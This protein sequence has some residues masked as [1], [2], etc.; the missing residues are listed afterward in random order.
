MHVF[1][2]ISV[3]AIEMENYKL[4]KQWMK[5]DGRNSSIATRI[6]SDGLP[7]VQVSEVSAETYANLAL[8]MFSFV[9][10]TCFLGAIVGPEA[11]GGWYAERGRRCL[12]ACRHIYVSLRSHGNNEEE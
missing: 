9:T 5:S 7:E 12:S 1:Q 6:P 10:L 3:H 2:N 4:Q 11:A 8:K